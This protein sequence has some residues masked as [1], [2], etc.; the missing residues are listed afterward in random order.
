MLNSSL[1]S[2]SVI[3]SLAEVM[4]KKKKSWGVQLFTIPQMAAQDLKGTL[5]LLGE[6]GY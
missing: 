1:A 5:K 4:S 6:I 3:D 2:F